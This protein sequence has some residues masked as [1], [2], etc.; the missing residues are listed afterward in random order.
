MLSTGWLVILFTA[1]LLCAG[2]AYTILWFRQAEARR[3]E[4]RV[5]AEEGRGRRRL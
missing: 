3:Q 1:L 4:A 2:M 5:R